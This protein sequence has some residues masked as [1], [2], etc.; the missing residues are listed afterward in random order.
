M[1]QNPYDTRSLSFLLKRIYYYRAR[2]YCPKVQRF[3]S[4][5]PMYSPSRSAKGC[6]TN[7]AP[8]TSR[9]VEIDSELSR[10]IAIRFYSAAGAIAVNV[11][12]I[13]LYTYVNDTPVNRIDPS[14]LRAQPQTPGCD[15]VGGRGGFFDSPCAVKCCNAHDRCY[16]EADDFCDQSSWTRWIPPNQCTTCNLGVLRCLADAYMGYLGGRKG[17]S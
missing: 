10:L 7:F 13:P 9:Y 5:A 3:G 6:Q 8:R 4:E 16:E 15:V 14:G 2:Y 12:E 11:Q 1:V 17:C